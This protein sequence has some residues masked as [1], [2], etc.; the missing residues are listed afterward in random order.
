MANGKSRLF[1]SPLVGVAVTSPYSRRRKECED[2]LG[3]EDPYGPVIQRI[4]SEKSLLC[5]K[6]APEYTRSTQEVVT[7]VVCCLRRAQNRVI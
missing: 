6:S 2:P 5:F 1:R 7:C 3:Q 4:N